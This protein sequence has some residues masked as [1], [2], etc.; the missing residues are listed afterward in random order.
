MVRKAAALAA[1]HLT[2]AAATCSCLADS[3]T[4][5]K[6]AQLPGG[7]LSLDVANSCLPDLQYCSSAQRLGGDAW[8]AAGH[9]E[10]GLRRRRQ[11]LPAR[12]ALQRLLCVDGGPD[13]LVVS[14][15][16]T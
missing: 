15:R 3:C 16:R 13:A 14:S 5:D 11:E 8:V 4:S 10:N 6:P 2:Q 9:G 1:Q 12:Q 7:G